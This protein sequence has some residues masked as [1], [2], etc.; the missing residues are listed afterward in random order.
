MVL[1]VTELM[2][3][4]AVGV[5][6]FSPAQGFLII[7]EGSPWKGPWKSEVELKIVDFDSNVATKSYKEEVKEGLKL[8]FDVL[9]NF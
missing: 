9:R 8:K 6:G 4:R 1:N 5:V 2:S 7:E 3:W